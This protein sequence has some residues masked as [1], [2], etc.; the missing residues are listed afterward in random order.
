MAWTAKLLA[1]EL[2]RT[3]LVGAQRAGGIDS[4]ASAHNNH[5]VRLCKLVGRP[6]NWIIA[7]RSNVD[8]AA[9]VRPNRPW[10]DEADVF[11]CTSSNKQSRARNGQADEFAPINQFAAYHVILEV[12][13]KNQ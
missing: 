12:V 4:I 1:D 13:T 8:F 6:V 3:G 2:E 7:N 9:M 5:A 10:A 11:T